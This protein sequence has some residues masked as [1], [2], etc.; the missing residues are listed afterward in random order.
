MFFPPNMNFYFQQDKA[1][2]TFVLLSPKNLKLAI[3]F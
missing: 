3:P 1:V 2:A